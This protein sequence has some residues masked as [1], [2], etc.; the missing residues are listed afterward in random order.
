MSIYFEICNG[1]S[2]FE[3]EGAKSFVR[4][5]VRAIGLG[6]HIDT[7]FAEY[8]ETATGNPTF[9]GLQARVLDRMLAVAVR[10]MTEAGVDPYEVG[11]EEMHAMIPPK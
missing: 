11:L 4:R 8:R 7:E 1:P 2:V 9:P 6:F 5:C 10:V 3:L